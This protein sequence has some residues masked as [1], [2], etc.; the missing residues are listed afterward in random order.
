PPRDA[1]PSLQIARKWSICWRLER[2]NGQSPRRMA[3]SDAGRTQ[4]P[5]NLLRGV[6]GKLQ[7]GQPAVQAA[8]AHQI[9]VPPLLDDTA[10]VH[11][12]NA[13][14]A[15]HRGK[16]MG[17]NQ[18]GAVLHDALQRPLHGTLALGIE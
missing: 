8:S 4:G 15:L 18:G 11:H 16:T 5:P 17:D 7:L 1:S 9:A 2:P 12:E 3:R 14:G 13:R 10:L 6:Q